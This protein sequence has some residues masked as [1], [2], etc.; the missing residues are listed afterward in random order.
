MSCKFYKKIIAVLM[1]LSLASTVAILAYAEGDNDTPPVASS[2]QGGTISSGNTGSASSIDGGTSSDNAPAASSSAVGPS[3]VISAVTSSKKAP[4]AA[5]SKVTSSK[6]PKTTSSKVK[7]SSR[8][9]SSTAGQSYSAGTVSVDQDQ[10]NDGSKSD[11]WEGGSAGVEVVSSKAVSSGKALS[12]HLT[13]P[14]KEILKLIWIPVLIALACIGVLLYTN[15]YLYKKKAPKHVPKH[16]A[17]AQKKAASGS[18][19]DADAKNEVPTKKAQKDDDP[20]SAE[21]F[22]HFDDN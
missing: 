22:F 14:K 1:V 11:T 7:S 17:K 18:G 10:Y 12:K 9:Y 5:S 21:N 19:A 13:N 20:F 15:L 16:S 2:S 8:V 3:S 6:K 4:T